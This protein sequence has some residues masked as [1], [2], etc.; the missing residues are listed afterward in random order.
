MKCRKV[1]ALQLPN[2]PNR[3]ETFFKH[4]FRVVYN[5]FTCPIPAPQILLKLR[6]R[7]V[8]FQKILTYICSQLLVFRVHRIR[9]KRTAY[10]NFSL[11]DSYR[12]QQVQTVHIIPVIPIPIA[13][14]PTMIYHRLQSET[15]TNKISFNKFE[16]YA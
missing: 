11:W 6:Y 10:T 7:L 3:C 5:C 8:Y 16:V 1:F 4:Q 2:R 12:C 14:D 13:I 9:E 15:N